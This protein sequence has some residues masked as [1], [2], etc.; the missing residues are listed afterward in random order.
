MES[1]HKLQLLRAVPLFAGCSKG[2]LSRI[3]Q[4]VEEM[5]LPAGHVLTEQGRVGNEF[6]VIV[7]GTVR[8]ERDGQRIDTMGPGGFLGEIAL[9][10]HRPRTATATCETACH[11]LVLGHR[12]FHTLMLDQ[13]SIAAAVLRSL[14]ERLRNLQPEPIT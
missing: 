2:D 11:V 10:D 12:E 13:P 3:E 9:V 6:F 1:D 7:D 14:G 8:I 4:L 5:D